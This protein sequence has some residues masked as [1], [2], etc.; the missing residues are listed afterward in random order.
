MQCSLRATNEI[1]PLVSILGAER[2]YKADADWDKDALAAAGAALEKPIQILDRHLGERDYLL[3]NRFTVAD[4]NVAS[5]MSPGLANGV[6][7]SPYP[8]ASTWMDRCVKRDASM[9]VVAMAHA[10]FAARG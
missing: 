6:D 1:D 5:V 7:L 8:N 2:A 9:R 3:G 10:E 4:L